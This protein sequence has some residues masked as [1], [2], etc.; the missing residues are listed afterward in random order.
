MNYKF[1]FLKWF[2]NSSCNNVVHGLFLSNPEL[3]YIIVLQVKKGRMVLF[4]SYIV[5]VSG[6]RWGPEDESWLI[7]VSVQGGEFGNWRDG[8]CVIDHPKRFKY[9]KFSQDKEDL[10]S[11]LIKDSS[12]HSSKVILVDFVW[13]L[14]FCLSN[15]GSVKGAS[16]DW[17]NGIFFC[18]YFW[19]VVVVAALLF[20]NSM[21]EDGQGQ[22]I[23]A[24]EL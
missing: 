12:G 11:N 6:V 10:L 14:W 9:V 3:V 21:T 15:L 8:S 18:V 5:T 24:K 4:G 22:L 20:C 19:T 17:L 2:S 16:T 7:S 1:G 13:I 23:V